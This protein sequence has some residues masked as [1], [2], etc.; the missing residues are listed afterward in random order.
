MQPSP[1]GLVGATEMASG[2]A[3]FNEAVLVGGQIYIAGRHGGVLLLFKSD[4]NARIEPA[5]AICTKSNPPA[6]H[7]SANRT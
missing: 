5:T 3:G 2:D 6:Q 4:P 1:D 7:Q